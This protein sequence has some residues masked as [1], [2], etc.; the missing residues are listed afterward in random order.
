MK[1]STLF[2]IILVNAKTAPLQGACDYCTAGFDNPTVA[3]SL[4]DVLPFSFLD[5]AEAN[6]TSCQ[7]IQNEA[8]NANGTT[9]ECEA[10]AQLEPLCCPSTTEQYVCDFCPDGVEVEDNFVCGIFSLAALGANETG[11]ASTKLYEPICCPSTSEYKLPTVTEGETCYICGSAD[12]A[13]TTPD[14]I[15]LFIQGSDDPAA[16]LTCAQQQDAINEERKTSG[17]SC[18]DAISGLYLF[19]SPSICG[20]SGYSPPKSCNICEGGTVKRDVIPLAD[21]GNLTCG[22]GYDT[23]QHFTPGFCTT[24]TANGELD[25]AV[26]DEACCTYTSS[27]HVNGLHFAGWLI[28]SLVAIAVV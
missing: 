13:M 19:A 12:V 16:Q 6:V 23:F 25:L 11:C 18:A 21:E 27:G 14:A 1:L 20:C 9:E 22:Q 28:A 24:L 15:P 4:S 8:A 3:I 5:D 2:T 10:I 7:D 26:L 17:A